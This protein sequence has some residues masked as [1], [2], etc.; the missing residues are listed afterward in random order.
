VSFRRALVLVTAFAGCEPLEIGSYPEPDRDD[1]VGTSARGGDAS[2]GG[3]SH[4]GSG[5]ESGSSGDDD[6][7]GGSEIGG[8][9]TGGFA[10]AG[11][12]SGGFAGGGSAGTSFAGSGFAGSGGNGDTG[13]DG[14][15][16]GDSGSAG[17]GGSFAGGGFGG[18]SPGG[19]GD[20]AGGDSA[21]GGS[22]GS[23]SG[24]GGSGGSSTGEPRGGVLNQS[25]NGLMSTCGEGYYCCDARFIATEEFDFGWSEFTVNARVT[26]FYPDTFEV[27]VGRFARFIEAF[28]EWRAAGHPRAG[29][30]EHTFIPGTGWQSDWPLPETREDLERK[31][32]S[33]PFVTTYAL[34][35]G[36]PAL[37]MNCVSWYEAFAFCAWDGKRLLTEAEWELVAK[38]GNEDRLY[39]WGNEEPTPDLAVFAC[40]GLGLASPHCEAGDVLAV[41]SKP[42][43]FSKHGL[44]DMTG[45]MA[46]WVFDK[47]GDTYDDPCLDCVATESERM[48]TQRVFRGGGYSSA[49]MMLQAE[50]RS[51]METIG[52]PDSDGHI[53]DNSGRLD[54]LGFR[55]GRSL[56]F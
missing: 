16:G 4:A 21:G 41:G 10:G 18:D 51:T 35:D 53:A 40:N 7:V 2:F 39:P 25:C 20:S 9:P 12:A 33:C 26:M 24:A 31:I 14:N 8:T 17:L 45:S 11:I 47:P 27:T 6:H 22:A 42:L 38:A 43:G 46:E 48:P 37:P 50:I 15:T 32:V 1:L 13:G 34:R 30:A 49:G 55:C 56:T 44:S 3:T 52:V 29:A 19:G 54:F 23:G 36:S 5:P 28:D